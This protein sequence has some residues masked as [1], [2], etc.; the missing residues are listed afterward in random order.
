MDAHG[1]YLWVVACA[2]RHICMIGHEKGARKGTD[3]RCGQEFAQY[4]H[5]KMHVLSNIVDGH[6][7]VMLGTG[8][9]G[10]YV[11]GPKRGGHGRVYQAKAESL[12]R[13]AKREQQKLQMHLQKC[14]NATR[15]FCEKETGGKSK[16]NASTTEN[17]NQPLFTSNPPRKT[18]RRYEKTRRNGKAAQL[19]HTTTT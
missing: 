15:Q 3:G 7:W 8:A 2:V 13:T 1:G 12:R 16:N 5:V 17:A 19:K 6:G 4:V 18:H 11:P 10:V 14:T 9:R